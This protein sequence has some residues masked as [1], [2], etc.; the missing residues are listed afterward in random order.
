MY[1]NVFKK[2]ETKTNS[3]IFINYNVKEC[4]MGQNVFVTMKLDNYPC[5]SEFV[6]N[7]HIQLYCTV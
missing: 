7:L 3:N 5:M 2:K 6:K 4:W 1:I